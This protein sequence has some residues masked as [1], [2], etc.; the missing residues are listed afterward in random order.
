MPFLALHSELLAIGLIS[1]ANS[2]ETASFES[3]DCQPVAKNGNTLQNAHAFPGKDPAVECDYPGAGSC[4]YDPNG[5]LVTQSASP[6]CPDSLVQDQILSP[7][8]TESTTSTTPPS[9]PSIGVAGGGGGSP[10]TTESTIST[11][12]PSTSS[13]AG[14][15]GGSTSAPPSTISPTAESS[16]PTT[17]STATTG[18][19]SFAGGV[20]GSATSGLSSISASPSAT[21]RGNLE[22]DTTRSSR[23]LPSDLN[24][25][26]HSKKQVQPAIIGGA[27]VAV[28]VVIVLALLLLWLRRRR[29]QL[30]VSRQFPVE[31]SPTPHAKS[32]DRVP[33]TVTPR[34]EVGVGSISADLDATSET[35]T[36]RIRRMEAQMET[37]LTLSVPDTALPVYEA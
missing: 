2:V 28:I 4:F 27:V 6:N 20:A 35:L 8:T 3:F 18:V 13:V 12:P 10:V 26:F 1:R 29:R 19:G 33:S 37:L 25:T 22:P 31:E 36:Q 17:T 11:T 15:G 14:D 32:V 7:T 21:G 5:A 30:D 23:L 24:L 9:T 16:T 34:S